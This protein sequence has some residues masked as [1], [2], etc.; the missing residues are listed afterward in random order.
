MIII[1]KIQICSNGGPWP[2]GQDGATIGG[3]KFYVSVYKRISF[4]KYLS[5][6]STKISL[7]ENPHPHPVKMWP[8]IEK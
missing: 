4:K 6:E 5:H 1:V 8:T 7:N 3:P 2:W